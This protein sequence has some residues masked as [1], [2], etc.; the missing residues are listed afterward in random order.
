MSRNRDAASRAMHQVANEAT[1]RFAPPQGRFGNRVTA[2]LHRA[3]LSLTHGKELVLKR[4][5]STHI[6]ASVFGSS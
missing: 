1:R 3:S 4:P 2:L 6:A 5:L